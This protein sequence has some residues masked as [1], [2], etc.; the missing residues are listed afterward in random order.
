MLLSFHGII[1]MT[2]INF[3]QECLPAKLIANASFVEGSSSWEQTATSCNRRILWVVC[4]KVEVHM[5]GH[6]Y[7]YAQM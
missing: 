6:I 3:M 7:K 1:L 5:C 2:L 4:P